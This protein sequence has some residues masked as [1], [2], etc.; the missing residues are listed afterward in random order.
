MTDKSPAA[1]VDQNKRVADATIA[2]P[3][4]VDLGSAKRSQI[5][6]LTKGEGPL[7]D[8]V[9]DVIGEL[10][11]DGTVDASAQAVI[12]VVTKKAKRKSLLGGLL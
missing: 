5:K 12:V 7:T 1:S 4:I 10:R 3:V 6:Q 2:A 9:L 8:R 11:N